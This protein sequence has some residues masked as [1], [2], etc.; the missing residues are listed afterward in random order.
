MRQR[1]CKKH[2]GEFA[3]Y[4]CLDHEEVLCP[5]C[6]ITHKFCEFLPQGR[7]LTYQAKKKFRNLITGINLRHNLSLST[8][9][10]LTGTLEGLDMYR[11]I[12][13]DEINYSF[14]EII[15]VLNDRREMLII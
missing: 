15:Q 6:L 9:K 13:I 8:T 2:P 11:D 1:R 14:D 3:R 5:K 7:E 10:K 4:Y 12:Q